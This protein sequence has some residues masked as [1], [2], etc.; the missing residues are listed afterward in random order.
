MTTK[1]TR[2]TEVNVDPSHHH[3]KEVVTREAPWASRCAEAV[4]KKYQALHPEGKKNDIIAGFIVRESNAD[5]NKFQ[6][7]VVAIGSGTAIAAGDKYSLRG[8][9]VHD[10]HAEIVA[11]RS[12]LR[13]LYHQIEH[14]GMSDSFIQESVDGS[15]RYVLKPFDLWLYISQAPCGDAAVFS[16][17]D[18]NPKSAK[19]GKLRLK[20]EAGNGTEPI[21]E[22]PERQ[23]FD[24]LLQGDRALCHSCSDK[25]MSWNI[26]GVQGALLSRL[27][28]PLYI[29]GVIIGDIFNAEHV[30]RAICCRFESAMQ[31]KNAQISPLFAAHHPIITHSNH[32]VQPRHSKIKKRGNVATN[33]TENDSELEKIDPRTG[34][35]L[36]SNDE[37]RI[38]KR[39]LFALF[40]DEV[41][42]SS[43]IRSSY[44]ENKEQ[45][46]TYQQ[47]KATFEGA[48]DDQFGNW[49]HKPSEVD[50]FYLT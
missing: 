27:L 26:L 40:C 4:W 34:R 24:G 20:K 28:P 14:S 15:T 46:V 50:D 19:L 9:V 30:S 36:T 47:A 5:P 12:L 7:R 38:S 45:A 44:R 31:S 6:P 41:T 1:K 10:C 29:S 18:G 3:R 49:V 43:D 37:S 35:L 21:N 17:S 16:H 23:S 48:I 39:S 13:W 42:P 22:R 33:W 11:R 2:R 8:S 25:L 32:N